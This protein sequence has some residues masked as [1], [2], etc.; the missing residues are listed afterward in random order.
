MK[1]AIIIVA[2]ELDYTD[3][4]RDKFLNC[5]KDCVADVVESSGIEE[6]ETMA[7][8]IVIAEIE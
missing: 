5:V 2:E 8:T 1:V 6:T 7:D 4:I 3:E